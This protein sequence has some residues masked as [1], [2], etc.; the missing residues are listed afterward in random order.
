MKR[1]APLAA[2]A[3]LLACNQGRST[4]ASWLTMPDAA[5]HSAL[6][7]PIAPGSTHGPAAGQQAVTTCNDCHADR[8][9]GSTYP[10]TTSPAA[11]FKTYTCTGCHVAVGGTGVYHD[12]IAGLGALPEHAGLAGFDPAQP[13]AFDRA[14]RTCHPDGSAAPPVYHSQLFPIDAASKHAGIACSSCH[15]AV[16]ADTSQ[17]KCALCHADPSK[18]TTFPTR[19]GPVGNVAILV[20]TNPP[21]ATGQPCT[22][23]PLATP[24]NPVAASDDPRGCLLCHA[25]ADPV[26][27]SGHPTTNSSFGTGPH[28]GAGC[29]TCHIVK[30]QLT[31]TVTPPTT[32]PAGYQTVD[33]SKPSPVSQSTPGCATCHSNG[34]GGNGL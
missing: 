23:S 15:G 1:L 16:R 11:S 28:Q 30:Y 17:L 2:L 22:T 19:H 34:C 33:F 29:F 12:D 13:L 6:Y 32:A 3:A 7:F 14:C 25:V 4:N 31:A 21:A 9:T 10:P 18:S 20:V 8:S 24:A 26:P 27:V 5:S